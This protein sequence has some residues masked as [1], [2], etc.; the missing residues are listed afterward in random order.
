[1]DKKVD[2]VVI[3]WLHN[4]FSL[5]CLLWCVAILLKLMLA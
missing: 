4:L 5:Y 3:I 1:M 2:L